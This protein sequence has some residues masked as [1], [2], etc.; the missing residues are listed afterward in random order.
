MSD[1]LFTSQAANH[2][3]VT[4][5][6]A[7]AK[8][9]QWDATAKYKWEQ[10]FFHSNLN[11]VV[12]TF[13]TKIQNWCSKTNKKLVKTQLSKNL[14]GKNYYCLKNLDGKTH[15]HP[16]ILTNHKKRGKQQNFLLTF[17]INTILNFGQE[18]FLSVLSNP[19]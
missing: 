4:V 10:Q 12:V 17:F 5:A 2:V 18:W 7:I 15:Y 6:P 8:L 16:K 13:L 14:D 1:R 9:L 19:H 3:F 11:F